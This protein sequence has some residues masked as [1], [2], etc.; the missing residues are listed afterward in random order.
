M[1]QRQAVQN[2]H[3]DICIALLKRNA[4]L[5]G[6]KNGDEFPICIAAKNGHVDVFTGLLENNFYAL[7]Y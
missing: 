7:C 5:N 2:G 1:A 3:A 6:Q 4:K